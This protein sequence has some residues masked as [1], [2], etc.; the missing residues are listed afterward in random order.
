MP[1]FRDWVPYPIVLVG[2]DEQSGQ[3]TPGDGLRLT[4]NLIDDMNAEQEEKAAIGK[5]VEAVFMDV[6]DGLTLPQFKLSNEAS[7]GEVWQYPA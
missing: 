5:R 6:G 7:L 3:P 1:G 2:L 4:T